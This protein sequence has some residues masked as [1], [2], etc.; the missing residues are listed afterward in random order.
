VQSARD[1][2]AHLLALGHRRIALVHRGVHLWITDQRLAGYRR[3]LEAAGCAFDPALIFEHEPPEASAGPLLE[4]MLALSQRPTAVYV[5]G[6]LIGL[7]LMAAVRAA[8]IRVPEELAMVVTGDADWMELTSPPLTSVALPGRELGAAA[9]RLLMDRLVGGR[10]GAPAADS[11]E[12]GGRT[13]VVTLP[14]P[15]IVRQ[16]SAGATAGAVAAA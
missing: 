2:T 6:N 1:A 9:A 11:G 15:L 16:S 13:S 7:R 3:A 8:G 14:A 12:R 4:R 5:A 10:D